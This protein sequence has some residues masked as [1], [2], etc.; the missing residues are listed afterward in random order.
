MENENVNPNFDSLFKEAE[1]TPKKGMLQR[2]KNSFKQKKTRPSPRFNE[3]VFR[4]DAAVQGV[5]IYTS[6]DVAMATSIEYKGM[7]MASKAKSKNIFQDI[8]GAIE[9]LC[10]GEVHSVSELTQETRDELLLELREKAVRA[11]A[12]AI[13]GLRMETNSIFDGVVD[14][15]V[16]GTAV[17]FQ[18]A[19]LLV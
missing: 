11:G 12:N 7:V 18:R 3:S 10:G 13:V 15:V 19:E 16:Y 1:A 17:H 14:M 8:C 9:N 4:S 6:N 2:A 5:E